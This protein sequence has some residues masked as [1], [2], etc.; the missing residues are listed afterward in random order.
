[1]KLEFYN[2]PKPEEID[3]RFRGNDKQGL[4]DTPGFVNYEPDFELIKKL[5]DEYQK[6][7]NILIIGHG[8]SITSFYGIYNALKEQAKKRAY[9]L[10]TVD[11]DYIFELKKEVK[12]ENTLVVAISKSGENTTQIEML[13]QFADYPLLFITGKSSPLRAIGEKLGAKIILHPDIGGRYTGLTEVALVPAAICGLE[14]K[15]IYEGARVFYGQY[16]KD[17]LAWMAASVLYQLEQK[18]YVDVFMPFYAHNLFPMSA[19]I[20]QLCHESFGKDGKGQTYFAHEAPESQHHTNQRFFGGRKNIC[21]FF[22]TVETFLHPTVN[23]FPAAVH[24]VQIKGRALFDINKIPLEKSM[25][26]EAQGTMED[27]RI[28]GIPLLH[29]T[30]AGF[31]AL[32]VGQLLAFWQLY[33]VYASVLRNVNPFDQPQVENSKNISFDKRLGYKGLL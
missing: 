19:I 30:V 13:M 16:Q 26:F 28:S 27:A 11:P 15:K 5:T 6:Y 4:P 7:P 25:Q 14:A 9:F 33:A 32:E 8:G 12:P 22:T 20:V 17:N 21:G 29:L 18:G 31:S 23:V 24:S 10:S 3:S 1:M 2:C